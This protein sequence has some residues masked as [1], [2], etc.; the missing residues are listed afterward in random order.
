MESIEPYD[1][2]ELHDFS[3]SYLSGF[4]ADKYDVDRAGVF[5]RIRERA[6]KV[7]REVIHNS[8][9]KGYSS[10]S[11]KNET[12]NVLKTDWQYMML[13]V[14]FMS[15][16]YKDKVYEFAM[17]G[18]TGKLAGTPPLSKPK[19]AGFTSVIGAVA[20]IIFFIGGLLIL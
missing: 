13:P 1:Y 19:L 6:D 17:N 7:S 3:M 10:I 9:G 2:R 15:Y 11:V 4:Y 16:K 8:I 20:A 18:Q 5:P 12:Y 14:W